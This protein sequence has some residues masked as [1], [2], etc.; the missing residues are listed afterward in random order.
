MKMN[1][2]ANSNR[3]ISQITYDPSATLRTGHH[4]LAQHIK[5]DNGLHS[6]TYNHE[7]LR[8]GK[9]YSPAG[10]DDW[11]VNTRYVYGAYGELLAQYDGLS[12]QYWNIRRWADTVSTPEGETIGRME[13]ESKDDILEMNAGTF[14]GYDRY[15]YLKDHTSTTL[16]TGLGSI[17]VTLKDNGSVAGYACPERSRRDDYYPFGLHNL[18]RRVGMPGRSSNT[19]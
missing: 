5:T 9:Q 12:H 11:S 8:I 6:Y 4:N 14:S 7:G 15:F 1:L 10:Q 16:S 18:S 2:I 13:P 3:N 19:A 17:R